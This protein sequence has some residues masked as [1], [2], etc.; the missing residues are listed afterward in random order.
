MLKCS[1][2]FFATA[3]RRATLENRSTQPRAL[4]NTE[5]V[6]AKLLVKLGLGR[7]LGKRW[8]SEVPN[9]EIYFMFNIMFEP[10]SSRVI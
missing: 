3:L 2:T 4:Y 9:Q 10:L 7:L 1:F 5:A 8:A 6:E